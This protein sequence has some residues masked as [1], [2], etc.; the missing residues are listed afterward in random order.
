MA[1]QS[2]SAAFVSAG[3][4]RVERDFSGKKLFLLAETPCYSQR[5]M[6]DDRGNACATKRSEPPESSWLSGGSRQIPGGPGRWLGSSYRFGPV[7]IKYSQAVL[8]SWRLPPNGLGRAHLH[9]PSCPVFHGREALGNGKSA[10]EPLA[11]TPFCRTRGR[12]DD[13]A[14][15]WIDHPGSYWTSVSSPKLC[16]AIP[17]SWSGRRFL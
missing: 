8:R 13:P 1:P 6:I 4:S 11:R 7:G 2:W 3:P 10:N 16:R 12:R 14:W 9:P 5:S 15:R 17:A